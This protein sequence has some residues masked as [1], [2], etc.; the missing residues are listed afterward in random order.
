L[1][2]AQHFFSFTVLAVVVQAPSH[3]TT[4]ATAETAEFVAQAL[5]LPNPVA[6]AKAQQAKLEIQ[7]KQQVHLMQVAE[8]K[9]HNVHNLAQTMQSVALAIKTAQA[10]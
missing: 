1:H 3:V 6:E 5:V 8:N 7:E 10:V 2:L 9:P 4:T